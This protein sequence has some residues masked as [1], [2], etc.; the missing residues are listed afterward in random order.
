MASLN[1]LI[2]RASEFV[3]KQKG[4]WD[5][6]EWTDF[7]TDIQ[8]RGVKLNEEAQKALGVV[9]E[10]VKKFYESSTE[11]AKEVMGSVSDQTVKFVEKTKGSWDHLGWE[12]FLKDIKEK[13]INITDDTKSYI[14]DILESVK[15]VYHSL[16]LIAKEEKEEAQEKAKVEPLKPVEKSPV[17]K[18]PLRKTAV[19]KTSTKKTTKR[20]TTTKNKK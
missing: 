18:K 1:D 13:G 11:T 19:R 7:I 17:K 12:S 9:L 14:G 15:K 5:H 2:K 6:T 4:K 10:S 3:E 20:K 8:K 16:P